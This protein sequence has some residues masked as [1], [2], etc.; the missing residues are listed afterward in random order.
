MN[1]FTK[2][3][4]VYLYDMMGAIGIAGHAINHR[5]LDN[6][7]KSMIENYCEHKAECPGN[8]E[9]LVNICD[10]CARMT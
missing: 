10:R 2:E 4:L 7:I 5:N 1:D 3:E 9:C 8:G 6:K